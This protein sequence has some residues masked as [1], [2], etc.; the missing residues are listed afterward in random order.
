[1]DTKRNRIIPIIMF[2]III[3]LIILF[4][5]KNTNNDDENKYLNNGIYLKETEKYINDELYS[6]TTTEVLLDDGNL[7]YTIS[8]EYADPTR[9]SIESKENYTYEE[10]NNVIKTNKYTFYIKDNNLC[11]NEKDC[12]EYLTKKQKTTY[13]ENVYIDIDEYLIHIKNISPTKE[14]RIYYI[15]NKITKESKLNYLIYDY[16][17]KLYKLNVNEISRKNRK[18]LEDKYNITKYPTLIILDENIIYYNN[19]TD[20]Y[21]IPKILEGNGFK[22]R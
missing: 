18:I 9:D 13:K 4:V 11:I 7:T 21:E 15:T 3:L 20:I 5:I 17:I 2:L 6:T 22:S 14:K 19:E 1:M 10:K 16:D 12:K 8:I